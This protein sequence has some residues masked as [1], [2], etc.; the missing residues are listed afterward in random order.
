[1]SV[2]AIGAGPRAE[3]GR[4]S[5]NHATFTAKYRTGCDRAEG[6]RLTVIDSVGRAEA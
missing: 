2:I 4:S 6:I 3:A 1:V 5:S